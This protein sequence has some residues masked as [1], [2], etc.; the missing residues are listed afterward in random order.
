MPNTFSSTFDCNLP[1]PP[2]PSALPAPLP[3]QGLRAGGWLR[4]WQVRSDRM[5]PP[6]M[7]QLHRALGWVGLVVMVAFL[8]VSTQAQAQSLK[9]WAD[10]KRS[11]LQADGRVLDT[12]QKNISHSEGQ[13]FAMVL[14]T[15]ANDRAAFDTLWTWTQNN[16][17]SARNDGL[18]A[19][20]WEPG[21][22]VTDTN[23][24]SDGDLFVAW[25]LV[26]ANRQWKL[27][28]HREQAARMARAI[29]EKMVVDGTPW[30]TVL[31]PGV[32][33]FDT[34]NGLVVNLSY[35]VFPAF[36]ALNEVDPHPQW[37]ALT[38]SGLRLTEIARFGRWQL[39]P[40]WL[41]LVNPLALSPQH[42]PRHGYDA[43]RI[44][45]YLHWAGHTKSPAD[46][47]RLEPFFK[48]WT[49]F[50]CAAFLPAWTNLLDNSID[51]YGAE[52]GVAAIRTLVNTG[53]PPAKTP[54]ATAQSYYAATLGLLV[55]VA[56]RE[57]GKR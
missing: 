31:K 38:R 34:P 42:P 56:A 21:R 14:A 51:S 54:S 12:A 20:R 23:T 16:L 5:T 36:E 32:T 52:P 9:G 57:G 28:I 15:A 22:G 46:K 10:W 6:R 45:L 27:P 18:L 37:E 11:Y 7:V 50:D 30:G 41:L 26:R 4:P 13:G 8:A 39:P 48:F 33:G 2:H 3:A 40:D 19:W 49:Q 17:A 47:A 35:W 1:A 55:E 24:A 43:V 25:A 53:K 29:R 44:P